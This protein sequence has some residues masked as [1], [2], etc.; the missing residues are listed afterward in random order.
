[1]KQYR[2][3][4]AYGAN[5]VC[6]DGAVSL[7]FSNLRSPESILNNTIVSVEEPISTLGGVRAMEQ[8]IADEVAGGC[9]SFV[10]VRIIS[11]QLLGEFE[12]E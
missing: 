7:S 8:V 11:F 2:Y 12:S 6:P 4:V 10:E 9:R 1:M 3:F 5:D